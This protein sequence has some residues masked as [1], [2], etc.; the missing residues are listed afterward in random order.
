VVICNLYGTRCGTI[1]IYDVRM[2]GPYTKGYGPVG[3][4]V[5]AR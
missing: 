1:T 2:Y 3:F 5:H 4:G